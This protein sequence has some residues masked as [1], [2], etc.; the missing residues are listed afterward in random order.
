LQLERTELLINFVLQL[1]PITGEL[2][3]NRFINFYEV[4]QYVLSESI[5][6]LIFLCRSCI[7]SHCSTV[8]IILARVAVIAITDDGIPPLTTNVRVVANVTRKL[9]QA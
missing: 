3:V 4:S 7:E 1:D 9:K 2:I 5:P 8:C 6:L